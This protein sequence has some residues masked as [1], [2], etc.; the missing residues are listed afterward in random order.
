MVVLPTP[1]RL[2]SPQKIQKLSAASPG[3]NVAQDRDLSSGHARRSGRI[4]H[5]GDLVGAYRLR[6]DSVRIP[7]SRG[8]RSERFEQDCH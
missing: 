1:T 3:Q 4:R 2:F 8:D 5:R 6:G 7:S